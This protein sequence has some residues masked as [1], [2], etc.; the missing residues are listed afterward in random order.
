MADG[1]LGNVRAVLFD[2]RGARTLAPDMLTKQRDG[3]L[4]D[5]ERVGGRRAS[6]QTHPAQIYTDV[7]N[8]LLRPHG[9][10]QTWEIKSKLMGKPERDATCMQAMDPAAHADQQ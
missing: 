6:P 9:K 7:V 5:S 8:E 3:L 2:V 1:R 10:E 4:I